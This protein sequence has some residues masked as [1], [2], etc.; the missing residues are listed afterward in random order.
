MSTLDSSTAR[1]LFLKSIE[2]GLYRIGGPILIIFGTIGCLITLCIFK[3]RNLRKHPCTIYFL[4]FNFSN[5][6]LIY[7]SL[8]AVM[9][10]LGFNISPSSYNLVCC[11]LRLYTILL[12][13]CLSSFYLIL[14]SMDRM[15]VTSINANTRRRSNTRFAYKCIIIGTIIVCLFSSH[16]LFLS[17]HIRISSTAFTCYFR[18]GSYVTFIGFYS[19]TKSTL[20]PLLMIAFGVQAIRNIRS[21][22][23]ISVLRTITVNGHT[24]TSHIFTS[25]DSK[26]IRM[27]WMHI[28]IYIFLGLAM[29]SYLVYDQSTQYN[30]KDS[31]QKQADLLWR[32]V[33]TFGL[34]MRYCVC[35]YANLL[36]SGTVRQ[37]IRALICWKPAPIQP[38][39]VTK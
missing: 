3:E 16:A 4:A 5:F 31:V 24:N 19:L 18:P 34:Y 8:M 10:E 15:L 7:S 36:V 1:I 29:T 26:L 22:R 12:F 11:R 28:L 9:L 37:Q 39:T 2:T 6:A 30:I 21:I 25:K 23:R 38:I 32:Y 33:G 20:M 17:E 14:A 35:G 27:V 13:D